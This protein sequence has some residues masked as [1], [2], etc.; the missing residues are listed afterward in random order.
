[1]LSAEMLI[2]HEL[3][4]TTNR[5]ILNLQHPVTAVSNTDDIKA[6]VLRQ[7]TTPEILLPK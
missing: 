2:V 7:I 1:M 6:P 3:L 4:V 5:Q